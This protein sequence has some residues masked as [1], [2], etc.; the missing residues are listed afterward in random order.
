[1]YRSERAIVY[2]I[3]CGRAMTKDEGVRGCYEGD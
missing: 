3:V 2:G 1:M